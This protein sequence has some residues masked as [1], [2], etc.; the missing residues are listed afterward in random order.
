MTAHLTDETVRLLSTSQSFARGRELYLNDAIFDAARQGNL[1]LG[2]CEGS[3]EP[4]YTLQVE[5]DAGYVRFADCSCP[6]DWGGIC[7]H[8][9]A[10]LLAFVHTP[11]DFTERKR[12]PDLLQGLEREA[13]VALLAQLVDDDPELYDG[14]EAALVNARAV[15]KS[16]APQH[17]RSPSH[18][19]RSGPRKPTLK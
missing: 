5:L 11:E 9:V 4:F 8:L 7:K 12:I 10:L 15:A 2:K 16:Q 17:A 6:Y 19:S 1:L 18:K 13:L 3:G 14:L